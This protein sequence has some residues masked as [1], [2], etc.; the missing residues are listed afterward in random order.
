M[1]Q[2]HGNGH[3][4]QRLEDDDLRAVSHTIT[5]ICFAVLQCS[6]PEPV[7][8]N[9]TV[10]VDVL[11]T[12][13]QTRSWLW[14]KTMEF[15]TKKLFTMSCDAGT[16]RKQDAYTPDVI[17]PVQNMQCTLVSQHRSALEA[18]NS[19]L[20]TQNMR[21]TNFRTHFQC[22]LCLEDKQE[23][24][25]SVRYIDGDPVCRPCVVEGIVPLFSKA[26]QNELEY[27][28][29]WG[30]VRLDIE[31][32]RNLVPAAVYRAWNARV[33]EYETPIRDRAYY[34]HMALAP[35]ARGERRRLSVCGNFLGSTDQYNDFQCSKCNSWFKDHHQYCNCGGAGRQNA[36]LGQAPLNQRTRG[37]EW[38]TC[39]QCEVAIE[40]SSGCNHMDCPYCG[41]SFCFICGDFAEYASGH[42]RDGGPCPLHGQP[43]GGYVVYDGGMFA[44]PDEADEGDNGLQMGLQGW[45]D[46][47]NG[48]PIIVPGPEA[49]PQDVLYY[50]FIVCSLFC[51]DLL[52]AI[53]T[54]TF[55]DV[56]RAPCPLERLVRSMYDLRLNLSIAMIDMYRNGPATADNEVQ[57]AVRAT[58]LPI[59]HDR[60][61]QGFWQTCNEALALA[62]PDSVLLNPQAARYFR[63]T[64]ERYLVLHAPCYISEVL[65]NGASRDGHWT[66]WERGEN[67][68]EV[69]IARNERRARALQEDAGE[70]LLHTR[71]QDGEDT[72]VFS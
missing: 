23:P 57:R 50:D 27:P 10:L 5:E 37:L 58:S 40:Q 19:Q 4:G 49:S 13:F 39:P 69:D 29:S 70:L 22:Q 65:D 48:E 9:A 26:L 25:D 64:F 6:T 16:A 2:I 11:L 36:N 53:N 35:A 15:T 62:G 45:H 3:H 32:Y 47:Y 7:S 8:V 59:R 67:M 1:A 41:E 38:E 72:Y 71:R 17:K 51:W 60:L 56:S 12:H 43:E 14:C 21:R 31:D 24:R 54:A 44:Q 63:Q 68:H 30:T 18:N 34:T 66:I 33:D 61:R 20:T 42:W 52:P 46:I 55:M 28:P